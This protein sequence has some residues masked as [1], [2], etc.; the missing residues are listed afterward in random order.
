[1]RLEA[2][3]RS[4]AVSDS[5]T[6]KRLTL[7]DLDGSFKRRVVLLEDD[8]DGEAR[9]LAE[10]E[11]GVSERARRVDEQ[12]AAY[13]STGW[14]SK[15]PCGAQRVPGGSRRRAS[16]DRSRVEEVDEDSERL[17]SGRRVVRELQLGRRER[18]PAALDIRPQAAGAKRSGT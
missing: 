10:D 9:G 1:M 11:P 18:G 2:S 14:S 17:D 4:S 12:K 15:R 16:W 13:L 8:G 6:C 3:G 5:V 7:V